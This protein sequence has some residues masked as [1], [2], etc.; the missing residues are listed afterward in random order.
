MVEQRLKNFD[1]RLKKSYQNDEATFKLLKDQT[2]KIIDTV[3]AQRNEKDELTEKR[4]KD[5]RNLEENIILEINSQT[6]NY[7]VTGGQINQNF[8]EKA[9]NL[10]SDV[11]SDRKDR[12]TNTNSIFS[13]VSDEVSLIQGEL[14]AE[15]KNREEAYD[16]IIKKLGLE[17]L[18]LNDTLNQEKKIREETHSNI[19]SMLVG[20]KTRL[21]SSLEVDEGDLGRKKEQTWQPGLLVQT[22]RRNRIEGIWRTLIVL[23]KIAYCLSATI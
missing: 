10:R 9:I 14:F 6:E 18:R 11:M 23:I 12:E 21:H 8:E 15:R 1:D 20:M 3:E 22:S 7:L 19:R 13:S 16:K 17:V 2:Q 4:R 5:L